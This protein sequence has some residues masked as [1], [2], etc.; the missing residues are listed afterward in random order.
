MRQ[1]RIAAFPRSQAFVVL[2]VDQRGGSSWDLSADVDSVRNT[3]PGERRNSLLATVTPDG[4]RLVLLV[5]S[6]ESAREQDAVA[7][8]ERAWRGLEAKGR[9]VIV[10]LARTD[11]RKEVAAAVEEA[12]HVMHTACALAYEPGVYQLEDVVIET[13]L[14]RSPDLTALLTSRLVPLETSNAPLIETLS[15]FLDSGQD[16]RR[17]ARVLHIHPNTLIYRL[18]RIRELTGLSPTVPKDI[19][20]LGAAMTA[21]RL[22]RK[23]LV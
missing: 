19:Q 22:T 6:A 1:N 2:V 8:A 12:H 16:R 7:Q 18:R 9:K 21:W 3:L 4:N 11:S 5:P 13:A 14:L 17:A 10:S 15:L 20:K 23:R